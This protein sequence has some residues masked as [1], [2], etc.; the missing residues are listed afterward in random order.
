MLFDM[1]NDLIIADEANEFM[2]WEQSHNSYFYLR[3]AKIILLKKIINANSFHGNLSPLE[4]MILNGTVWV[5]LMLSN[6][7]LLRKEIR[8]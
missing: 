1:H 3:T 8:I 6:L 7:Y 2:R 4:T 5:L